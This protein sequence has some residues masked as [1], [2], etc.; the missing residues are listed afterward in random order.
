MCGIN[1]I[2]YRTHHSFIQ[3][4]LQHMNDLIIHRGPDDE[5]SYVETGEISVAL[6]M[7]RLSIIDLQK[8][9]QPM[10][11]EDGEI[12][13]TFNGEIYNF[14]ELRKELEGKGVRFKTHS[15]TEVILRLYEQYGTSGFSKLEGMYAF[16]IY[17]KTRH[18]VFLA[19]DFFGEKPLYYYKNQKGLHWASELKSIIRTVKE[20]FPIHTDALFLYFQLTYIPYPYTIYEGIYKL[21]PNTLLSF[22]LL[23]GQIHKEEIYTVPRTQLLQIPEQEAR[24]LCFDKVMDSV[25][26]RAIADVGLGTYLSGGVDS[27]I[28]SWC[29]AQ[30]QPTIDT[31]TIGFNNSK[32][33]ESDKARTVSGLIHSNHHEFI[34]DEHDL[35]DSIHEIILNF[36]EPFAD[37]SALASYLVAAK[38]RQ[39]VKVALTGDGGDEVFGGYNKY[40]IG[41]LNRYF[42][43]MVPEK[44]FTGCKYLTKPLLNTRSDD[45]GFRY[46]MK[47]L[48]NAIDYDNNFYFNFISLGY[49]EQ[50]MHDLLQGTSSKPLSALKDEHK[51]LHNNIQDFRAIDKNISLEGDML[52]K[53]DRTSML[54]SLECRA[55]FLNKSLWEFTNQLPDHYLIKGFNKKYLLKKAFEPYFPKNFFEQPKQGFGVPVGDWLRGGLQKELLSYTE[56][57]FLTRQGIFI[58]EYVQKLVQGHIQRKSDNSFKVWTFYC[59]Q[60]WYKHIYL[61]EK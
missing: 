26:S 4:E 38:T 10:F 44:I 47:K 46:K 54:A 51:N 19:R 36:D 52:V 60:K 58:P 15:D 9:G 24:Q 14:P 8:G 41:K 16:C 42:T 1:G 20:E 5:G 22:D 39:Y 30:Q 27:S 6:G 37:S 61:H 29:L 23:T 12:V 53:V 35:S 48:L 55:P 40:Y 31:F 17:D 34:I 56:S 18:T 21:E 43:R 11:S 28:V 7:R 50:E 3:K 49:S 13:L 57:G 25:R 32:F 45:R 59:F 33:D 2:A